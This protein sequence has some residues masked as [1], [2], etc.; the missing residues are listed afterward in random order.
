MQAMLRPASFLAFA[1]L[2][3]GAAAGWAQDA[4]PA[5]EEPP[6]LA[7][8]VAAGTLPPMEERLPATPLVVTL[9]GELSLGTYGGTLRTL[10][11]RARDIRLMSVYG[12][13][14]LMGYTPDLDLVPD[15]LLAV[16]VVEDRDYTLHLRP[17]H[18]WSDGAPFTT[19]DFRY[20]WEDIANNAELSPAGPPADLLVEGVPP[21]VEIVDATT[22]RYRWDQPNPA[23]LD[24]LAR[25]RPVFIYSPAHYLRQYHAAYGDAGAIAEAVTEAN[26]NSWAALH[27]RLDNL[28]RMD[29]PDL[30]TLQPWVNTTA[31]PANRFVFRRNPYF[32]R[33]DA[34]GRQL[35]YIDE[36]A[37]TVADSRLIPAMANAGESDLQARGLNFSDVTVLR[38][39]EERS[40]YTT[41]LWPDGKSAHF[42]LYPNLN[43]NDPVWRGV[44]RDARFRRALSM[45]LDRR[46]INQS[47]FFGLAAEGGNT[48]QPLSPLY[49]DTYFNRYADYSPDGANA[50]LD[51]M[52][53]T[54]RGA[55]NIRL[56]PDGR[57]L[58]IIIETAGEDAQEVD[59]LE[60]VAETWR[61][62]GVRALIRATSREVM[63]NRAYAGE[64]LMTVWSGWDNG[65][66]TPAMS[67]AELA[68]TRQDTLN[69]P[70]WGQFFQTG[71]EA[72]EPVNLAEAAEL[73]AL[74]REW[75]GSENTAER[76]RIW[77][78]MLEIHAEQQF[79]I[80]VV[81]AVLQPIAV[82]NA[83]RNVPEHGVYSWDPGAQFGMYRPDQFWFA[84]SSE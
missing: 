68:P 34:N 43:A 79:I 59:F 82:D 16:D 23:F 5:F 33:M 17:G 84:P 25:A 37:L 73:M 76:E 28:Y 80:G 44:L 69:W 72:G 29:N 8:L 26:V 70:K 4:G 51:E 13:A 36:V 78:R 71:G 6:T 1:A 74:Y 18:R 66:A 22:I 49:R 15:L 64:A 57:P 32:H 47:L 39:G 46:M 9:D 67:P 55:N 21:V 20:W 81:S 41:F 50:L 38:G 40:G 75:Q 24:A 77:L 27:N 7:P 53:L 48:M 35:P 10:I 2:L 30:P 11:G 83:L 45:G 19:E 58:E 31:P 63:R 56:L 62:I 12:Y 65:V 42:A 60:L 52:G 61:E 14:R 54:Q 3:L